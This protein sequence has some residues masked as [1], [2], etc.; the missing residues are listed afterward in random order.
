[1]NSRIGK[2][3]SLES[4]EGK[5]IYGCVVHTFS[6]NGF[7]Y[8]MIAPLEGEKGLFAVAKYTRDLDGVR[9]AVDIDEGEESKQIGTI[10]NKYYSRLN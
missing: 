8:E 6:L 5:E 1:M 2:R 3:I 4:Q 10:V 7:E 9:V